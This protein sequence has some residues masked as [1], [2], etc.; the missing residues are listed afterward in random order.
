MFRIHLA[1]YGALAQSVEHLTFNQVVRGS[2]PR[3]FILNGIMRKHGAFLFLKTV[4]AP[5]SFYHNNHR[6]NSK[7]CGHIVKRLFKHKCLGLL[8][9][10]MILISSILSGCII[11]IEDDSQSSVSNNSYESVQEE[12]QIEEHEELDALYDCLT[13]L[14]DV[15]IKIDLNGSDNEYLERI[16]Q[17]FED[18]AEENEGINVYII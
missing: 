1:Q 7:E 16:L 5:T 6:Y 17:V 8:L 9:G 14:R 13:D 12:N 4:D 11:P 3:C 2:N 18:A 10:M 15:R